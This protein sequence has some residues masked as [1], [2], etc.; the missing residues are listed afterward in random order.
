MATILS[1]QSGSLE[2]QIDQDTGRITLTGPDRTGAPQ[3]TVIA[4]EPPVV[5]IGGST[6]TIGRVTS[7]TPLASGFEL[8]QDV[9]GASVTA[10]L[11]FPVD[12]VMR[13]E[14]V[15]WN[16]LK[17]DAVS[18]AA[19]SDAKEHFYGFGEKFNALDQAGKVVRH[20]DVRQPGQQGRPVLQG[21]ALVHQHPR[22]WIPPRLDRAQHLRHARGRRAT[23][24]S[25][26]SV[27]T[28][29]F[30]VVYGPALTDVLSRYTG[31]TGRPACR[32]RLRSGRG[33]RPTSGATGARSVTPSRKFRERGIP[34]SA[35]VFDSPWEI[36]YNDFKFN[37]PGPTF[38][39]GDPQNTQFGHPGTFEGTA[40]P[41]S[42]AWPR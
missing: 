37:I 24:P 42:R 6:P 13:Y 31:L 12:S 8:M 32:R 1:F 39:A 27:G 36:A 35:F 40:F 33:S 38:H 22:L 10:Q 11:T 21:R 9:G 19:A 20:P 15:D 28:L 23:T 5:T 17:P 34:V 18:V 16:G 29:A 41:G 7:S 2:A 25:P 4:F 14:V 3:A 26:T 30:N